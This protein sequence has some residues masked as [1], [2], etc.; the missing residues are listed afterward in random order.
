VAVAVRLGYIKTTPGGACIVGC[1]KLAVYLNRQIAAS[2]RIYSLI[3]HVYR[4]TAI[5]KL[6]DVKTLGIACSKLQV[7]RISLVFAVGVF[8]PA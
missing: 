7:D 5:S 8:F 6:R 4:K 1:L 2:C 3:E